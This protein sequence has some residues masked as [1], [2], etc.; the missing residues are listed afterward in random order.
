MGVHVDLPAGEDPQQV[1]LVF[2]GDAGFKANARLGPDR[3]H[4]F[5]DT[6]PGTYYLRPLLK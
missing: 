5:Y 3:R 4:A 1:F 6:A 2:S